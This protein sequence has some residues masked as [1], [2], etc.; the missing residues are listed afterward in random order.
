MPIHWTDFPERVEK[1][2]D[3]FNI[4][5]T[6]A[7]DLSADLIHSGSCENETSASAYEVDFLRHGDELVPRPDRIP[8]WDELAT[9]TERHYGYPPSLA[10][11]RQVRSQ[12]L[13]ILEVTIAAVNE[14][15]ILAVV[16]ASRQPSSAEGGADY[17]LDNYRWLKGKQVAALFALS[18]SQVSKL[19]NSSAFGTNGK[20]DHDRRIDILSVVKWNLDRLAQQV[21]DDADE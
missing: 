17:L 15:S 2:G 1:F 16:E 12:A 20:T 8:G 9:F 19:A 14:M 3:L 11:L 21:E 6:L 13:G 18:Q 4:F 7:H 10:T 5:E